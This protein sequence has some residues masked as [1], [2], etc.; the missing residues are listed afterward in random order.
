MKNTILGKYLLVCPIVQQQNRYKM[1]IQHGAVDRYC[2][3]SLC[4]AKCERHVGSELL[5]A[6]VAVG[7]ASGFLVVALVVLFA[8]PELM[9][10]EE[11][12]ID[13]ISLAA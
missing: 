12:G 7:L 2:V 1:N 10:G 4:Q 8:D 6:E 3:L 11:E 13:L 9:E 5:D